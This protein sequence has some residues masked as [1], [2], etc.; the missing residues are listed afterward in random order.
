MNGI[1]KLAAGLL[2]AL[3]C[4]FAS[5]GENVTIVYGFGP[6]D[7]Q[8]QMAR[9]LVNEAN[10]LQD[11]YTF[12]F[13]IKPG[14]GQSVAAN[15]VLR[16]PNTILATSSA[17]FVRPVFYPNESYNIPD[18]KELL[19]LYEDPAC[20]ASSKFKSW[21]EVPTDR[22]LTVGISGMGATT[23]LIAMQL[24]TKYPKIKPVA[25]KS[26]S[27][28]DLALVSGQLDFQIGFLGEAMPWVG[29]TGSDKH[30]N[31]L[32]VTG[33]KTINGIPTL[34]S[35]GFPK[36]LDQMSI[37]EHLVV[38]ATTSSDK[39][40]EWRNILAKASQ[41]KEF[42]DTFK[43]NFST[44]INVASDDAGQVWFSKQTAHWK[45]VASTVKLDQ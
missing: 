8:A 25:F 1:K 41:T 28:A 2:I 19:P 29:N 5:A 4:G 10:K 18:F 38:P 23:H 20:I 7:V 40:Q 36:V 45:Q 14:A 30:L 44:V 39:T 43:T 16:T 3:T 22:V 11:K 27:E 26:T 42:R 31:I 24:A 17:F 37:P 6:G 33:T 12:L 9:T 13:D 32:S 21:S 35:Q 34:S 15:Y